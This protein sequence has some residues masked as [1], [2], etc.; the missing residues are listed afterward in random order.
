MGSRALIDR[1]DPWMWG[2]FVILLGSVHV[3]AQAVT[4]LG[5]WVALQPRKRSHGSHW[6]ERA[7]MSFPARQVGGVLLVLLPTFVAASRP[8]SYIELLPEF[9]MNYLFVAAAWTG[10]LQSSVRWARRL[11]PAVDLTPRPER[12]AWIS[13]WAITGLLVFAAYALYGAASQQRSAVALAVVVAGV[14]AVGTYLNW[15]WMPLMRAFG[16]VRPAGGRLHSVVF[17]IADRMEIQPR[18]VVE[19]SLPMANAFAFITDRSIGATDAALAVLDDEELTAVCAHE[20]GHLSEP[21]RVMATRLSQNFLAGVMVAIPAA[22]AP[23]FVVDRTAESALLVMSL[24]LIFVVGTMIRTRV[25][26]RMEIRADGIGRQFE[27]VPGSYARALEKLYATNMVP[28]VAQRKKHTHPELYDR[29]VDAGVP[30][31]YP[32]P[33]APPQWPA[34]T[35]LLVAIAG[36]VAGGIGLAWLVFA[37]TNRY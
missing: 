27:P 15:G 10:V 35:G 5:M 16:L 29:L 19:I 21:R 14:L 12:A 1:S 6:S 20:L 33:A 7:R 22:A 2:F 30:P 25:A 18:A 36:V 13:N 34:M 32:R 23:F 17:T 24:L 26:R 31:E 3:I 8:G 37:A 11:N 4:W 9:A 28:V